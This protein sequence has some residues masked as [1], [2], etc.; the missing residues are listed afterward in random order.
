M[1]T[2]E[3]I[4]KLIE[5]KEP[6]LA[7]GLDGSHYKLSNEVIEGIIGRLKEYDKLEERRN[8]IEHCPPRNN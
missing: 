2:K 1:T 5:H 4:E 3:L 6:V 7:W 8:D